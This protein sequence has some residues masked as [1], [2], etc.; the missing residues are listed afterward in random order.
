MEAAS[1]INKIG[2][3]DEGE[4]SPQT[5]MATVR[6]PEEEISLPERPWDKY[7]ET[8]K[9]DHHRLVKALFKQL[10]IKDMRTAN[11]CKAVAYYSE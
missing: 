9:G 1:N 8:S 7:S 11:H 5:G 4:R 2:R 10:E 3:I 6:L